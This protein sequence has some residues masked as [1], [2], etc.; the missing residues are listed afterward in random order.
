MRPMALLQTSVW[1]I[2]LGAVAT[3]CA[4][5]WPANL[6]G[7]TTYVT[8]HG[9]SMIPRFHAG[10][11]AIVQPVAAYRVGDIAAYRSATLHGAIVLHRIVAIRDGH[12]TFK[13]DNN[14]FRD[15]DHPTAAQIVGKLRFR[16]A[17]GGEV[18]GLLARPIVLFPLLAVVFAGLA[19]RARKSRRKPARDRP[20]TRNVGQVGMTLLL[21]GAL[22]TTGAV[23]AA[24]AIWSAP[25]RQ[26]TTTARPYREVATIGYSGAAPRGAVYPAGR[27]HT[28][29]P[30]FTNMV[31]YVTVD[32]DFALTGLDARDRVRSDSRVV[33][34]FSSATGWHRT[35]V[36]GPNRTLIGGHVHAT[37][38]LDLAALHLIQ[39]AFTSETGL[40]T[41]DASLRV[42][43]LLHPG[44]TVDGM[45]A[46]AGLA[47]HLDFQLTP[48]ELVPS[49]SGTSTGF[50]PPD[51]SMTKTGSVAVASVRPRRFGVSR[52]Q[53]SDAAARGL[54]IALVVATLAATAAAFAFERLR[55]S[56][57]AARAIAA[58][59]RAFVVN[60]S[61]LPPTG[62]RP[63][64]NVHTMRDL[65]R[66]AKLHE[67][68]IVH[69]DE[70]G[71]DRFAL[72][73]D[74]VVYAFDVVPADAHPG[75]DCAPGRAPVR[76]PDEDE[77][78]RWAL[79]GLEAC[80]AE[81]RHAQ[82]RRHLGAP[83]AA[84]HTRATR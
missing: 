25:T 42:T 72:F 46:G 16:I 73:T 51:A 70:S 17:R 40:T 68:F 30:V 35:L 81:R 41:P 31:R 37:A 38:T 36:V 47:P 23:L 33:A 71:L 50:A 63:I 48:V 34:D 5:M 65:T 78:A 58:R 28:G 54:A 22:A 75:A 60:V 26:A 43:W 64:V 44:A 56:R 10:D 62:R 76:R 3:L 45:Q 83:S 66:L 84:E 6:G 49:L 57:G 74:S 32:L 59:Y 39:Q 15:P 61:S 11:L 1:L 29:D 13:G 27:I 67:E 55:S 69:A 82:R 24:V 77:L 19:P 4:L 14:D 21:V 12:F 80:A 8:T 20:R 9:T 79:A 53:V 52:L 7:R 2:L 18:R